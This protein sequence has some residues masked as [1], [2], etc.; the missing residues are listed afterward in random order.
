MT[1]ITG[2]EL[3]IGDKVVITRSGYEELQVGRVVGFTPKKVRVNPLDG[4][5][6][7][8]PY[9]MYSPRAGLKF[10]NQVAKVE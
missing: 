1:D 9:G 8:G 10:S 4:G 2:K 5:I 7:S 6:F 3:N